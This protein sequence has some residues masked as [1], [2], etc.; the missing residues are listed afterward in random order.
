AA[1]NVKRVALEMGG[2]SPNIV[3]D[4]ADFETVVDNALTAAFIH[5]GQV[6]SAGCRGIVQDSIYD[7]CVDESG[8]RA[9]RIRLG[10]GTDDAS[11]AGALI[12]DEHRAKVEAHVAD[13]LVAG[14]R[15]GGGGRRTHEPH[16]EAGRL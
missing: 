4:D 10:H 2:K 3:F 15:L 14:A 5:S 6:C 1:V 7:R 13:A 8:R 16:T 12:S 9:E 11:E